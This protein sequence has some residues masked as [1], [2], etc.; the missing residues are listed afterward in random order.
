MDLTNDGRLGFSKE[1]RKVDSFTVISSLLNYK[2]KA[3]YAGNLHSLF[4]TSE[5][6]ILACGYNYFG[7]N[8]LSSGS[9]SDNVYLPEEKTIASDATFC[10][11]ADFMSAVFI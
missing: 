4:Q 6:K 3:A 11:V 7:Q 9:S 10:I 2:I 5:G 1:V 8:L